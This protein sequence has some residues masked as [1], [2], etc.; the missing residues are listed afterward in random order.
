MTKPVKLIGLDYDGVIRSYRSITNRTPDGVDPICVAALNHIIKATGAKIVVTSS[1]RNGKIA[2]MQRLLKKWGVIGKVIGVT[3]DL[4]QR[5]P[6]SLLFLATCRGDELSKWIEDYRAK[7]KEVGAF[8]A[9]DDDA[10]FG[11]ISHCLIKTDFSVGLTME[12]AERA[13]K[14][15]NAPAL[16]TTER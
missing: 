7:G 13:I 6:S 9:I 12:H 8:I 14:M 3:P 10:D 2:P 1:W 4:C 15:L 16:I 11:K 5:D